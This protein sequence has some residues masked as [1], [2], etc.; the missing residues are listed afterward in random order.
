MSSEFT[1]PIEDL[2]YEQAYAEFESIVAALESEKHPL[3]K[4]IGLFERGQVLAQYCGTL[5][6][7]AELKVKQLS[8]VQL[9]ETQLSENEIDIPF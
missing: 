5:L 6:D 9:S 1:T 4:S 7:K 2:T 8:E 3:E